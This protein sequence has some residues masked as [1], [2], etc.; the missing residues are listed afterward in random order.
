MTFKHLKFAESSTMQAFEKL[1]Q[2]KGLVTPD[3]VK[4][5]AAPKAFDL[6][7][8]NNLLENILKLAGGLRSQ[9]FNRHADDLERKFLTYKSAESLYETSKETGE[10]VVDQAHP[11]GSHKMDGQ[12]HSVLTIVD[13]KKKVEEVATKKPTGKLASDDILNMVKVVLAQD[14]PRYMEPPKPRPGSLTSD[15]V[16]PKGVTESLFPKEKKDVQMDF[17]DPINKGTSANSIYIKDVLNAPFRR[18]ISAAKKLQELKQIATHDRI[19][20]NIGEAVGT[21]SGFLGNI[22]SAYATAVADAS[23]YV[24]LKEKERMAVPGGDANSS[25]IRLP[26]VIPFFSKGKVTLLG[27]DK[28]TSF[29][30]ISAKMN[31]HL[32]DIGDQVKLGLSPGFNFAEEDLKGISQKALS[33]IDEAAAELKSTR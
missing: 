1:A 21:Y 20:K 4:K 8:S 3:E 23:K 15:S 33:L 16:L 2:A 18:L 30:D 9:G 13:L 7:P 27:L 32:S 5:T 6:N 26:E 17:R 12:D 24:T 28:A 14:M 10:D 19:P 25:L 31:Q 29:E 22:Y 11:K